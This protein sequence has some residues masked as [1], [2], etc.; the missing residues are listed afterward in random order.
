MR[1]FHHL[2]SCL[3]MVQCISLVSFCVLFIVCGG[4]KFKML[5]WVL[6]FKQHVTL[7]C[8]IT[9]FLLPE[10][11]VRVQVN[12][13]NK[14]KI[15]CLVRWTMYK[16]IHMPVWAIFAKEFRFDYLFEAFWLQSCVIHLFY[17]FSK[18]WNFQ[19]ILTLLQLPVSFCFFAF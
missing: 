15:H 7:H 5:F 8:N 2:A 6:H 12:R 14:D 9:D 16:L 10:S 1:W 17:R 11:K 13:W 19:M 4:T 18:S 3:I